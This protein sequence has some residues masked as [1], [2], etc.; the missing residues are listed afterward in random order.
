MTEYKELIKLN[1]MPS[2][3]EI[4]QS[5]KEASQNPADPK[6]AET[7]LLRLFEAA[8]EKELFLTH[9]TDIAQL[10]SVS[11]FLA[12]YCFSYPDELFSALR[13]IREPVTKKFLFEQGDEELF[14]SQGDTNNNEKN[15]YTA[16]VHIMAHIA[17]CNECA[18]SGVEGR[19]ARYAECGLLSCCR[20]RNDTWIPAWVQHIVGT[21]RVEHGVAQWIFGCIR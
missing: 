6:R 10:F 12:N 9:L 14:P 18:C 5:I 3:K 19:R 1:S 21:P 2:D 8:P 13:Q 15:L 20:V 4:F 7:N 17:H 16:F 11:Q